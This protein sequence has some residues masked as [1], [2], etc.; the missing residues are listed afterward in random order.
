MTSAIA[1]LLL[2]GAGIAAYA[3]WSVHAAAAWD[4]SLWWFVAAAPFVYMLIPAVFAAAYFSLTGLF[5]AQR[6]ADVRLGPG[7]RLRL[8]WNETVS[9]ALSGPL[10]ILYRALLRDPPPLPATFPV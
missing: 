1:F 10:V 3:R 2:I 4:V 5:G 9:L 6:P 8:F 7:A